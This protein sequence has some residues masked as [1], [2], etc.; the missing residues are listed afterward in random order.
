MHKVAGVKPGV[1]PRY[2]NFKD[3]SSKT[4]D[5]LQ[6]GREAMEVLFNLAFLEHS[7]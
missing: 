2:S 7:P 4:D 5:M 6:T 1:D 3:F